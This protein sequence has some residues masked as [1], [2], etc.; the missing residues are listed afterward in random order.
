M[1]ISNAKIYG[2]EGTWDILIK[3][4]KIAKI[5]KDIA[6]GQEEKIDASGCM[7]TGPYVDSHC[8]L[9]YVGTYG[10]PVY[11]M[12]GTLF[13]GIKIWGERKK[14]ITKEDV[15]QR[16]K[17]VLKWEV[18]HG[19]QFIRTH[20]NSDEPG[21]ISTQAL[22]EVK[23]EMKDLIDVQIVAFPQ[24]GVYNFPNGLELLEECVA[25]GADA[26]G[27]IPHYEDTREDSVLSLHK[28]FDLAEKHDVLVDVHCDE[29]DDEQSRSV[30]VVAS[31]AYKRGLGSRV[32]A[33]H[34]TAMGSYNNAYAYKLMGLLQRSKI[35]FV[36]NPTINIHLQG[37]YDTYPRRRG[38]TRVQELLEAGL[39]VSMGNDDIMDPFYPLGAGNML[40]VLHMGL[41]VSH[42]TGYEQMKN[43]LDMITG[44]GAVTLNKTDVYGIE[45][46]KPANM[47]II[48]ADDVY[49]LVRRQVKP[50]Y[51]IRNGKII[52]N[53]KPE[54]VEVKVGEDTEKVDYKI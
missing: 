22:L 18:A 6:A 41:H 9:D 1:L 14:T 32:T 43:S 25:L 17:H 13:E 34:T 37:R 27:A 19:T 29:T 50:V 3:D 45:E 39:N 20:V 15:K 46:G 23:E 16:A 53:R 30:E 47:L 31:E 4:G 42:L 52:M 21:H 35:N 5:G 7:V 48:A 40:E 11:N 2:K 12:S 54:E 49:D 36:S 24:H 51:S 33:S 44:N 26:I 8:H 38:I 28:M 10:D